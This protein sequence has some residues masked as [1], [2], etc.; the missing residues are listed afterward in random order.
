MKLSKTLIGASA[1]TLAFTLTACTTP[2]GRAGQAIHFTEGMITEVEV[3]DIEK[4]K[5]DPASTA[6]V[7]AVG[8]AVAGQ[9]IGHDTKS[10][11]IGAGIGAVIGGMGAKIADRGEGMRLTVQTTDGGM[12]ILDQPYSCDFIPGTYIRM[13]NR[14]G[15]YQVQVYDGTRYRT[16]VQSSSSECS[17][18]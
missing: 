9:I 12:L 15:S 11:L 1:L 3:I 13:L 17:F 5:Y 8:G 7:G 6:A 4:N 2:T 14:S 18:E 16:A 10:T